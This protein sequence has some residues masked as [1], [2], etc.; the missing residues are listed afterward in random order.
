MALKSRPQT[1][2]AVPVAAAIG[3]AVHY[4]V[5]KD[6]PLYPTHFYPI[7]LS[8]MFG[9]GLAG[10]LAQISFPRLRRWMRKMCPIL[11]AVV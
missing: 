3:L 5:P 7:F 11:G 9:L 6:E 2:L 1:L 4:F 10:A 8:V